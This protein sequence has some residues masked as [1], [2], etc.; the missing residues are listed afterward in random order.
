MPVSASGIRQRLILVRS[1]DYDSNKSWTD[2]GDHIVAAPPCLL[3]RIEGCGLVGCGCSDA[4]ACACR[5]YLQAAWRRRI[6]LRQLFRVAPMPSREFAQRTD[7][8]TTRDFAA[9]ERTPR[10]VVV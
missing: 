7:K 2:P 10:R 3:R 8:S 9:Q 5:L 6:S 4:A 1:K